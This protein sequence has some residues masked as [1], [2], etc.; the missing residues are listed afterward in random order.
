M[1]L[2]LAFALVAV[3]AQA[4]SPP[5]LAVGADCGTRAGSYTL[6]RNDV[7]AKM[8]A[9]EEN[10]AKAE[11]ALKKA[12]A[13]LQAL[14]AAFDKLQG[15]KTQLIEHVDLLERVLKEQREAC[16]AG[17]SPAQDVGDAVGAAWEWADAPLAFTAG[18]GMCIGV[19]WGLTQVQR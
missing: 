8:D 5:A 15:Q 9:A 16:A 7:L 13:D 4:P 12:Q 18:A 11:A 3:P 2:A 14:D 10:L 1:R 17:R 19:A 6:V